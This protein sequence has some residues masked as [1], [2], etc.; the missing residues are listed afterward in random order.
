MKTLHITNGDGAAEIIK[1]STVAGDVLPWRDPMHHGPFPARLDLH[2]LSRIRATYLTGPD[3]DIADVERGFQLRDTHLE[4]APRYDHV[5]LW[6]EHDL[7]DQL[8]ILQL[9]DWFADAKMGDTTLEL[10]CVDSF[11]GIE[12]FRGIGQ[13]DTVQMAS[14]YAQRHRV[15]PE[16][17]A[18]AKLGWA[19]FRHDDPRHLLEFTYGDLTGLPYLKNALFRHFE[20][21]PKA[22]TGLRRTEQQLLLLAQDQICDPVELFLQNMNFETALYLGDW[23]TFSTLNFLCNAALMQC[24]PDPFWHPP[25]TKEQRQT[26]RAQRLGITDLGRRILAGEQDAFGCIKRDLWLGG[27]H[28]QS[29]QS[30]WTWDPDACQFDLFRA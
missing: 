10:I 30:L 21:Y 3:M 19:A 22:N 13:L 27:V 1:Q 14:L 2:Q 4:A 26:F 12:N 7:L 15:S 5:V 18:K 17:L 8:Q 20:E 6:F 24:Q 11:P 23:T 25:H 16:T 9:L 29:D 28:L